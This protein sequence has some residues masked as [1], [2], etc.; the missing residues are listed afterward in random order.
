MAQARY[1]LLRGNKDIA[2]HSLDELVKIQ[3][4]WP[5]TKLVSAELLQKD[6]NLLEARRLLVG[7]TQDPNVPDWVKEQA[8]KLLRINP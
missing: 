4:D 1:A 3:P 7:L 6:G 5:L 8:D 2:K